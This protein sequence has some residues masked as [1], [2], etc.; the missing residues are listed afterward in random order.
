M[1]TCD[2]TSFSVAFQ[3]YQDNGK[4]ALMCNGALFMVER[5]SVGP[6]DQHAKH[7]PQLTGN[8]DFN[9][10]SLLPVNWR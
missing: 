2:F 5:I 4:V 3:S 1:M 7:H 9:V 6:L 10:N 8:S